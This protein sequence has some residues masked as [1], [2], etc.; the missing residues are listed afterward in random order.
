MA[1][2]RKYLDEAGY[3]DPDEQALARNGH[4]K[5]PADELVVDPGAL[6]FALRP[7]FEH[8]RKEIVKELVELHETQPSFLDGQ[9]IDNL[10]FTCTLRESIEE[11]FLDHAVPIGDIR[12]YAWLVRE[13]RGL[14][15]LL[16]G[17]INY[18]RLRKKQRSLENWL[19]KRSD[20]QPEQSTKARVRE[21]NGQS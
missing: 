14:I 9:I 4:N 8:I 19:S 6:P 21:V 2:K 18:K 3:K 12:S 5:K 17:P 11:M 16:R 1:R 7:K 13:M 10:A 15:K 20:Y